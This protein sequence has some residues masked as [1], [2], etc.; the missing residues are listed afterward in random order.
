MVSTKR[1]N[2]P[3]YLR[4]SDFQ[5]CQSCPLPTLAKLHRPPSRGTSLHRR[6]QGFWCWV[7]PAGRLKG[8]NNCANRCKVSDAWTA[9]TRDRERRSGK[10]CLPRS[11]IPVA[12]S[13]SRSQ[14]VRAVLASDPSPLAGFTR[15]EARGCPRPTLKACRNCI[16]LRSLH[17]RHKRC[18]TS[19]AI[20][21][22]WLPVPL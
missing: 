15:S 8:R 18:D 14:C 12:K 20:R 21:R 5:P 13:R 17:A 22:K 6:A 7:A 10:R 9:A 19:A 11:L 4:L 1:F 16:C 3:I 2:G